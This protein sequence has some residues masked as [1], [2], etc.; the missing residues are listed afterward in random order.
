MVGR[1]QAAGMGGV[2]IGVPD[3]EFIADKDI[4]DRRMRGD[5]SGKPVVGV[6]GYPVLFEIVGTV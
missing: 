5:T 2:E 4:V 1:I 6:D 3:H